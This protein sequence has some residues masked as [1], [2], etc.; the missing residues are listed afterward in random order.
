MVTNRY[1]D[2]AHSPFEILDAFAKGG[3]SELDIRYVNVFINCMVDEL[4]GKEIV[5][6]DGSEGVVLL[7]DPRRL[8]YPIVEIDGRV[9][10]TDETLY[11]VRMKNVLEK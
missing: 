1:H 9:V 2:D 10:S 3:Y 6:S 8:L 11:C 7:V 4:Q 5:M